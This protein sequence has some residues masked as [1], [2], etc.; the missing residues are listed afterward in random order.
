[1][2]NNKSKNIGHQKNIINEIKE[3][4]IK[5][6]L[7]LGYFDSLRKHIDNYN[8]DIKCKL[9][10]F[11]TPLDKIKVTNTD[12]L[13]ITTDKYSF[14]C[15]LSEGEYTKKE[16]IRMIIMKLNTNPY[17]LHFTYYASKDNNIAIYES[18][19]VNFSIDYEYTSIFIPITF[20]KREI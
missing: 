8:N 16:F 13:A 9:Y 20:I 11:L 7:E 1:M 6:Y 4:R 3:L 14:V 10:K 12:K 2:G 5:L 19:F 17:D 18:S 15:N